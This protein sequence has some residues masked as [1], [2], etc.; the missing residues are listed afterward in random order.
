MQTSFFKIYVCKEDE[1]EGSPLSEPCEVGSSITFYSLAEEYESYENKV[2][3]PYL[4]R[5]CNTAEFAYK[6]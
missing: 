4:C 3:I 2:Y 1:H 5:K 6:I